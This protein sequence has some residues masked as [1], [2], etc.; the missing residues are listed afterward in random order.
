MIVNHALFLHNKPTVKKRTMT[1][2]QKNII[3]YFFI[4]L[5]HLNRKEIILDRLPNI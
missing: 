1:S 5:H 4:S 2:T 3:L